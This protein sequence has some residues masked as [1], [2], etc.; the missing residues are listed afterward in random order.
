[1]SLVFQAMLDSLAGD[2]KISLGQD[3]V[4][5]YG[6]K[7][8]LKQDEEQMRDQIAERFQSLG[9][10]VPLT[11]ELIGGLKLDRTIAPTNVQILMKE[12]VLVKINDDIIVHRSAIEK[13]IADVKTLKAKNPKLGVG[14]FKDLTGVTRK[15]AIPLLEY[16]DRQRITRR[17]GEERLI[18]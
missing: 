8:I 7:V 16:L 9:L 13:L 3:V 14:E 11:D 10:Q 5:E 4:Y 17:V 6:R 2:K 12:N 1:T 18:L 15:Y